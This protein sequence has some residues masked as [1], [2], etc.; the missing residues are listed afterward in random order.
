MTFRRLSLVLAL[1]ALLTSTILTTTGCAPPPPNL[2]PQAV[3][4][5]NSQ[6]VQTALDIIRDTART[7]AAQVPPVIPQTTANR[8][9]DWHEAAITIV[10]AAGVGWQATVQASLDALLANLPAADAALLRPYVTLAKTILT[11]VP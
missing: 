3:T 7:A 1:T 11:E 8:V 5:F 6:R 4:A 9:N 10:H 2:T